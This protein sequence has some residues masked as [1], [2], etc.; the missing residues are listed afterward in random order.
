MDQRENKTERIEQLFADILKPHDQ[1]TE[2]QRRILETSLE[3]FAARGYNG[4]STSEIAEKAEVAEATIFKHFKTKKGLFLSIVA[5]VLARAATPMI[6]QTLKKIVNSEQ[7]LDEPLRELFLD[8]VQLLDKNWS[9]VKVIMRE[10]QYHAEL[11]QALHDHLANKV[12]AIVEEVI[13]MKQES[14]Q[15]R[16]DIPTY[17][18][19]RAAVSNV[20]GYVVLKHFLPDV[21][22]CENEE[23]EIEII[24][25]VLLNGIAANANERP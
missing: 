10:T 12:Y 1:M 6:K 15:L 13:K 14:G 16:R 9:L 20:L 2:K 8:R 11:W 22:Q 4:V 25:D 18:I 19:V 23:T 21:M 17:A 24:V 3:M 5:P 7:A